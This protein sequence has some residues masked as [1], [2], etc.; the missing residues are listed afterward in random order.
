M[1][2]GGGEPLSGVPWQV[3]A[4]VGIAMGI[5]LLA[6]GLWML[7]GGRVSEELA[8]ETKEN[9]GAS[10][11]FK[12]KARGWR[13]GLS[14]PTKTVIGASAVLMGYHVAAWLCPHWW[15]GLRI[16]ESRW[17]MLTAGV[18]VAIC[19]SLL[20]DRLVKMLEASYDRRG[21]GDRPGGA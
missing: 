20:N 5:A 7:W 2:S 17:W 16:P 19:G 6:F 11:G 12:A 15:F 3:E 18:A 10:P 4:A 9:N 1:R 14:N 21:G 13:D 8:N